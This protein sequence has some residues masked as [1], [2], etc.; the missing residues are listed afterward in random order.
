MIALRRRVLA[1]CVPVVLLALV[2]CGS[3]S[4]TTKGGPPEGYQGSKGGPPPNMG[5]T[6]R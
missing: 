1:L 5:S 4:A 6:K 3:G 2:G